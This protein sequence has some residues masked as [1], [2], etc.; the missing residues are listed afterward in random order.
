MIRKWM[1]LLALL[2]AGVL[3]AGVAAASEMPRITKEEVKA[4]LGASD[5]SIIDRKSVV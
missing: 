4:K 1:I 3:L 5:L 2:T